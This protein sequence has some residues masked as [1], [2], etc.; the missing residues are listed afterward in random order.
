VTGLSHEI[1]NGPVLFSLLKVGE[2]QINGFVPPQAA[3]E[4]H[5]QEG[6]VTLALQSLSIGRLPETL[7]LFGG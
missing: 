4:Q 6:S 1:D 2:V 7:A 5:R 3:G